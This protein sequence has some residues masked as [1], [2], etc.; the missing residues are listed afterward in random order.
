MAHKRL[1]LKFAQNILGVD[2]EELMSLL[3]LSETEWEGLRC[4]T[5]LV[6]DGKR[7]ART[8]CA[9]TQ[10]NSM[11][12]MIAEARRTFCFDNALANKW[13]NSFDIVFNASQYCECPLKLVRR[14][15]FVGMQ[16]IRGHLRRCRENGG[17]Y[18]NRLIPQ[19]KKGGMKDAPGS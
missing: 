2:F 1:N 3:K 17:D 11:R 5:F 10:L 8:N 15:G 7:L 6:L 19:K 9:M 13:F 18:F 4:K 14:R 12:E 16:I